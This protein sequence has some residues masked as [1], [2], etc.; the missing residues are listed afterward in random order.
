MCGAAHSGAIT[1]KGKLYIWGVGKDGRLGLGVIED[2]SIPT[3]H[4]D[5][6]Q[7]KIRSAFFGMFTSF[8]VTRSDVCY[9]W[10]RG[11]DGNLGI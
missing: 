6:V 8:V 4:M 10:G 2:R 9:G 5:F 1:D 11:S 3:T 7:L